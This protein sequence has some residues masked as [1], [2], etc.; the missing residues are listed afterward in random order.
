MRVALDEVSQV[1]RMDDEGFEALAAA[2]HGIPGPDLAPF[3]AAPGVRQA[4]TAVTSPLVQVRLDTAGTVSAQSHRMWVDLDAAALLLAVSAGERQ[5]LWTPPQYL[6]AA[7]AKIVDLGP[8]QVGPRDARLVEPDVLE[9]LFAAND[10]RRRSAF[11]VAEVDVAWTLAVTWD[12]GERLMSVVDGDGGLF[13][14]EVVGD[15]WQLRPVS[16]TFLWRRFT[17][18][19]PTD[20]ELS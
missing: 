19:L 5:L 20:E 2:A 1:L 3:L 17:S 10:M 12:A 8:R 14:V 18:M 11:T 13:V 16:A 6:P 9:D 7:L 4:L 15:S